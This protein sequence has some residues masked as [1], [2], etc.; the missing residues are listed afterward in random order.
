MR[1]FFLEKQTQM[2]CE[3]ENSDIICI[4][5]TK[6]KVL[7]IDPCVTRSEGSKTADQI[8]VAMS[9][10]FPPP[11]SKEELDEKEVL[12]RKIFSNRTQKISE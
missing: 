8:E 7:S 6:S 2:S 10:E 1:H 9:Q 5:P 12:C 4:S 3:G 11:P